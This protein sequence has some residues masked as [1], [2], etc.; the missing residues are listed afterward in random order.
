MCMYVKRDV[1][2]HTKDNHQYDS[3]YSTA[4]AC[5]KWRVCTSK[6]T[7]LCT[8]MSTIRTMKQLMHVNRGASARQKRRTCKSKET[9]QHIKRDECICPKKRLN[10]STET[11]QH[12]KKDQR[13]CQKN[14]INM[15]KETNICQKRLVQQIS[16]FSVWTH[17]GAGARANVCVYRCVR[18]W[19]CV[20]VC[21]CVCVCVRERQRERERERKRARQ[22]VCVCV[23]VCV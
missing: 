15:S 14:R 23:S 16:L 12:I 21:M 8:L 1:F 5:Q 19:E 6:E 4:D 10:I 9:Y 3:S 2:M 22:C 7:Y 20:F 13:I 18:V 17:A 11:Y